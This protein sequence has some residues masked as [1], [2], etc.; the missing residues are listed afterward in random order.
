MCGLL[1]THPHAW[2]KLVSL[3]TDLC[4]DIPLT[5]VTRA[6]GSLDCVLHLLWRQ[7]LSEA[8]IPYASERSKKKKEKKKE[9]FQ[10][11]CCRKHKVACKCPLSI[12]LQLISDTLF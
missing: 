10:C 7:G 4:R 12:E 2:E 9:G 5:T 3:V 8:S 6:D 11:H 1:H